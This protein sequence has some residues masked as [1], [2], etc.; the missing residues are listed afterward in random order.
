LKRVSA[1][2]PQAPANGPGTMSEA[3][4]FDAG[5]QLHRGPQASPSSAGNSLRELK[6]SAP[7]SASAAS[8]LS[9]A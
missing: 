9:A 4:R 6:T 3:R 7:A 8:S 2:P 1:I 5:R